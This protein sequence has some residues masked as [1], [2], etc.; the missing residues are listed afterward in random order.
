[1]WFPCVGGEHACGGVAEEEKEEKLGRGGEGGPGKEE[2]E[3]RPNKELHLQWL[4]C[5]FRIKEIFIRSH[6]ETLK[7]KGQK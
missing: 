1:M 6:K 4:F 3:A 2:G 5:C 7:C